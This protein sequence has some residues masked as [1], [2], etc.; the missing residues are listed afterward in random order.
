MDE[1]FEK[2]QKFFANSPEYIY[3]IIAVVAF[4]FFIGFIK[5]K[6]WAIDPASGKQRLFYNSFGRNAFRVVGILVCLIAIIAGL[7]GFWVY[8]TH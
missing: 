5:N 2:L 8:R 1:V 4:I 7:V 6:D 3:L